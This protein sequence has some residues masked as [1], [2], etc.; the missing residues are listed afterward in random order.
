MKQFILFTLFINQLLATPP[1]WYINQSILLKDYEIIGY[2]EGA[3]LEE[4][5]QISKSDISK[6]IQTKI[7]SNISIDKNLNNDSYSKNISSNINE[8][9]NIV[10]TNLKV[11][12]TSFIDDKYYVAIKYINLPFNKKVKLVVSDTKVIEKNTNKYLNKTL[13]MNELKQEFGFYPKVSLDKIILL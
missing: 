5:K 1:H 3:T 6:M 11:I 8:K 7:S 12:K 10:L 4:A 2:G 13:L 9:S